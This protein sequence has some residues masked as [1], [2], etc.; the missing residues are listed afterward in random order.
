MED[1]RECEVAHMPAKWARKILHLG[2]PFRDYFDKRVVVDEADI[3]AI[4][5]VFDN[6]PDG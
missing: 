6:I 4:A 3:E 2:A 1:G 5:T